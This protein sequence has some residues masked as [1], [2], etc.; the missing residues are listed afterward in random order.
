[1]HPEENAED[2]KMEFKSQQLH[3][4]KSGRAGTGPSEPGNSPHLFGSGGQT[5]SATDCAN[6]RP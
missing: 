6:E 4:R 3:A 5:N 1:M 2:E